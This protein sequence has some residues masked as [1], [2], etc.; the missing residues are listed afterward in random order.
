M[1]VVFRADASI[2][3]GTGHVMRC[4][5]LAD[6]LY[7]QGHECAFICREHPGHLGD[8]ITSKGY[9]LKL[10]PTPSVQ[11]LQKKFSASHDY[12][13]WL[14]APWQEDAGQT[15]DGISP[16]KPDWLVV[17]HYALDAHWEHA[18]STAVDRIMVIDDLANRP[19]FANILL[20]QNLGRSEGDYDQ[21]V[22]ASCTRIVG[23]EYALLRPEFHRLRARSLERR[24][25]PELLRILVSMGG[26]DNPNATAVVLASLESSSLP[27]LLSL[28]VVIGATAP[29]LNDIQNFA[30][31]SRFNITVSTNVQDMAERMGL[32]DL[33][34]GAAGS[35]SWERCALGL[36]SI[37]VSQAQNQSRI[38]QALSG[39]GAAIKLDFPIDEVELASLVA[40]LYKNPEKLA[41]IAQGASLL[42]DGMGVKKV[43]RWIEDEP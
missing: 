20:D 10:L 9:T 33:S 5:T 12:S 13:L 31:T 23:P 22:P 27:S 41:R 3:I 1:L 19:H 30:K 14:G 43:I 24:Y 17:D 37:V 7:R 16:R 4:L 38:L 34:I 11:A 32:A 21:L 40:D 39:A 26:M 28:D 6:E 2:Q 35:T 18:L 25:K 42:C 36:P 15:L 8:L 29:W